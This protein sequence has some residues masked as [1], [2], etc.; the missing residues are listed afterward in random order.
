MR[1]ANE[2]EG[3][4]LRD[5]GI[6]LVKRRF[7]LLHRIGPN[8]DAERHLIA[9]NLAVTRQLIRQ[10]WLRSHRFRTVCAE[11]RNGTAPFY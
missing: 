8:V 5:V 7:R 10:T 11:A 1:V 9:A 4:Y 2:R 6:Q 3:N